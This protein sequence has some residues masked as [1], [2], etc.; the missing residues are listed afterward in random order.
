M[1]TLTGTPTPSGTG[2]PAGGSPDHD[3][4]GT[5]P[6]NAPAGRSA[7][8]DRMTWPDQASGSVSGNG[9]PP[10]GAVFGTGTGIV[11]TVGL[12]TVFGYRRCTLTC[13]ESGNS[14]GAN[15]M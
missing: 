13:R 5:P 4:R 12:S 8:T 7:S 3:P 6:D 15:L 10:M 1:S 9:C 11:R 2:W 14:T